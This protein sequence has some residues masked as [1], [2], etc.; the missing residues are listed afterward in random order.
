MPCARMLRVESTHV[1]CPLRGLLS[2]YVGGVCRP[3]AGEAAI[4]SLAA[5]A[6]GEGVDVSSIQEGLLEEVPRSR[7]HWRVSTWKTE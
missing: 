6:W 2:T 1:C 3:E 5:W 4:T 7:R